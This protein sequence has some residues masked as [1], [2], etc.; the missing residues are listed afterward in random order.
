MGANPEARVLSE[1]R[2]IFASN[3]CQYRPVVTFC[4]AL[5]KPLKEIWRLVPCA[6]LQDEEFVELWCRPGAQS[7]LGF[8]RLLDRVFVTAPVSGPRTVTLI[9]HVVI[10]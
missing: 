6:E 9:R 7:A 4:S 10:G 2:F 5:I 1:T 8:D 3:A